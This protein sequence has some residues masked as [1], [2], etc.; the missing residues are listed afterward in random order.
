VDSELEMY[1]M[2]SAI[3]SKEWYSANASSLFSSFATWKEQSSQWRNM[4][5]ALRESHFRTAYYCRLAGGFQSDDAW[6]SSINGGMMIELAAIGELEN[7][8]IGMRWIQ[9]VV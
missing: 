9:T 8:I 7:W 6:V 4:A 5:G 3:W 1:F 2:A